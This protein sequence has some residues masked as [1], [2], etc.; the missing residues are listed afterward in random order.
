MNNDIEW[1]DDFQWNDKDSIYNTPKIIFCSRTHSQLTQVIAEL[2]NTK[3]TPITAILASRSNLCINP[4]ARLGN[5]NETCRKLIKRKKGKGQYWKYY[6]QIHDFKEKEKS[7]CQSKEIRDIEDLVEFGKE[8]GVC[9]Y[10]LQRQKVN[11][12]EL[13]VMP[14]NYLIDPVMRSIIDIEF[15]DSVI[16]IDEA[17]NIDSL[18]EDIASVQ[19]SDDKLKRM[20]GQIEQLPALKLKAKKEFYEVP[21][22]RSSDTD[23]CT[24]FN[25]VLSIYEYIKNPLTDK[26]WGM[27]VKVSDS[28]RIARMEKVYRYLHCSIKDIIFLDLRLLQL[29]NAKFSKTKTTNQNRILWWK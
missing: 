9:P 10:Y 21:Y 25:L 22:F 6:E 18:C 28:S 7:N 13:I 16:I 29:S 1:E 23:I 27:F 14:Y 8:A 3:Y 15:N 17:H 12:S 2:K 24:V 11:S 26:Y 20:L 5:I 19:F 4:L